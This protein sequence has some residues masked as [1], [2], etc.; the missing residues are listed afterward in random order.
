MTIHLNAKPGEIAETVLLPGDPLRARFI[1]ENYFDNAVQ[2]NDVRGM[3]GYTGTFEGN[4]ISVQGTGMGIPS[5][6]IYAHELIE[7]YGV[8]RLIRVGS[9]GAL[10]PE[11]Q[12]RD[13][14][15]AQAA[16]TDSH[17]NR[18]RFRGMD[19]APIADFGLLQRAYNAAEMMG[20]DV[21]VGNVLSSD[22]FY[23]DKQDAW[24][25]WPQFN[26]LAV[27]METAALYTL[28]AKFKVQALAIL[29]VS[30]NLVHHQ[31]MSAAD[32]EIS[33]RQMIELALRLA[34]PGM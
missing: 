20:L 22:T 33:L 3:F 32:R 14:V 15:L 27:E 21:I 28:A 12:L 8:K 18:L 31:M 16:C 24:Q 5:I 2:H 17:V 19:F 29:T 10:V 34:V 7:S 26:V 23:A 11:L 4:R 1:A 13:V 30:D 6:S 9:C 25:I